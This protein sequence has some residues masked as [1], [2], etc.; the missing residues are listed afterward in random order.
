MI[1]AACMIAFVMATMPFLIYLSFGWRVRR[2]ELLSY[3]IPGALQVYFDQFPPTA[4]AGEP[5][6]TKRFRKQFNF[7]YG[8]RR[9]V[10]PTVLLILAAGLGGAIIAALANDWAGAGVNASPGTMIAAS[11]LLGGFMWTIADELSRVRR[12]DISGGDVYGWSFRLLICV[13][14]GFAFAQVL[15]DDAA[16]PVVFFLG[17]FPTQ[18]LLTIAR[19]ITSQKFGLGDQQAGSP[20]ELEQLQSVNRTNAEQ[21]EDE[22]I[23]T[24]AA[25]AW[26]DPIALTVRTNFDL[27]YVLDCMSQALFVAYLGDKAK[28][29]YVLSLRGA[30]EVAT[31]VD[32]LAGLSIPPT[33][34]VVLNPVQ[35]AAFA[36]LN[37]AAQILGV[38]DAALMT[39]LS[40]VGDDPYTKFI[41]AVWH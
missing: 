31:L 37:A 4:F 25:L 30:Q 38:S 22:G 36:T 19:R 17:A 34:G 41:R 24:I 6:L 1:D 8:R 40:E 16:V 2:D 9:Y 32:K 10:A 18:T 13:P 26:A 14:L 33:S 15:K 12:R 3:M 35:L 5:D 27:N 21:F 7:L 28:S 11:A 29:L 39:T 23:S 20:H